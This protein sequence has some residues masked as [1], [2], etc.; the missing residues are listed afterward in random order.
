M[1]VVFCIGGTVLFYYMI[2]RAQSALKF[3]SSLSSHTFMHIF[4]SFLGQAL[5]HIPWVSAGRPGDRLAKLRQAGIDRQPGAV[6]SNELG[7]NCGVLG[8]NGSE[9]TYGKLDVCRGLPAA[10]GP[11]EPP[12]RAE[13][14]SGLNVDTYQQ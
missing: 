6:W 2:H 3:S 8:H 10:C 9:R 11:W 7:T 12:N 14:S 5:E 1:V 13:K 4:G